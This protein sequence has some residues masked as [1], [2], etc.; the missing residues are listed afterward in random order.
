MTEST[1]QDQEQVLGVA[2]VEALMQ[3]LGKGLRAV[4]L[5]LP[6]NPVYQKA[7]E[8][9]RLAFEA[10]WEYCDE[11][12]LVVTETEFHW[13]GVPVLAQSNKSES[14]A[15]VLYKDG[16]RFLALRRG[17]EEHE[18]VQFLK[19]IQKA[20]TL[21][22]DAEDDLLTLLWE[23][24]FELIRHDFIELAMDEAA[25]LSEAAEQAPPPSPAV[26]RQAVEEEAEEQQAA[27]VVS[28]EEFDA[29]PYFLDESE[30]NY[31]KNEIEREYQQD[32]RGNI[33]AMLFDLLELQTYSTVRAELIDILQNFIPYL[34]AVG[35]FHAVASVLHELRIVLQRGREF[36][37]EHRRILEDLPG[38]LSQPDPLSQLLQSLDE[39][40]AHPSETDLVEL[41][42]ELRPEAMETVLAWLPRL[43]TERVKNLLEQAAQRLAQA[44][45]ERIAKAL[46]TEDENVLLETIRLA[47]RLKLPPV[48]PSLGELV[49]R[50]GPEIR[51]AAVEALAA[52]G[53]PLAMKE[54]E[55]ALD[56][57]DRDVR[58]SAARTLGARGNR[59][60]L[61]KIEAAVLGKA[62]RSADLSEK[63]TFF[64]AYGLLV[65]PPG[66]EHLTAMLET[67]GFLRRKEDPQ[68]RACS[69]MALGK[70]GTPDAKAA[71]KAALSGEKDPLVRN[72]INKAM[73]EI[74]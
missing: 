26:V 64:E 19:A 25:P 8:N 45:P 2:A 4:Q 36:L 13:E 10:V 66:I 67:K 40:V 68:V 9:I 50:R 57:K 55:M 35:D 70:I 56:D 22:A 32:L 63:T 27:G 6:N 51:R 69:A 12:E 38:R 16:V 18:I 72:A 58:I 24:Q 30:I 15:W 29:T 48:V 14:L 65:G 54:L 1:T 7:L 5:Y 60:A 47:G 44:N 52:I 71:L 74:T 17:V 23:Q 49:R 43:T 61:G 53:S 39:A 20:R 31:L 28:I 62:L 42:R 21:P 73:R 11:L 33:L 59:N 46:E 34:L 3:V 37:P 41:F